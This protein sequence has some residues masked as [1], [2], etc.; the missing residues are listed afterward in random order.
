MSRIAKLPYISTSRAP[1]AFGIPCRRMAT[2]AAPRQEGDI[3]AVF[4]SLSGAESKP[5]PEKFARIK[6]NYVRGHEKAL[7]ASWK[8]LLQR[9]HVE[10]QKIIQKKSS[11]IPEVDFKDLN[12]GS[13]EFEK[14][15]RQRGVAV[16]R[17]VVPRDEAREYK[18]IIEDYVKANPWTKGNFI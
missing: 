7:I 11:I 10:N 13:T 9:L 4:S 6:E 12:H 5:L 17:G 2:Q 16:I 8:R 18:I 15:V 14:L 1:L 3:S